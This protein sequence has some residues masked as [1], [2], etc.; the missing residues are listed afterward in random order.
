MTWRDVQDAVVQSADAA[1][2]NTNAWSGVNGAGHAVSH[3]FGFGLLRADRLVA[4]AQKWKHP[5]PPVAKIAYGPNVVPSSAQTIAG[6]SELVEKLEIAGCQ[7]VTGRH[8]IA[9]LRQVQL[10]LE[11]TGNKR[12]ALE[13]LLR[14]PSG[15]TSRLLQERP[16]DRS[17]ADLGHW[18]FMS[19][20]HWD[21]PATGTWVLTL[22][23]ADSTASF[24][25]TS[26]TLV[27][28]GLLAEDVL[29]QG[30][31]VTSA[32]TRTREGHVCNTCPPLAYMDGA[33]TCR[34]CSGNCTE[35]CFGPGPEGCAS[36]DG[37]GFRIVNR[38]RAKGYVTTGK[39]SSVAR[40][41]RLV[42]C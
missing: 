21:E 8:C 37:T 3:A 31:M 16:G 39:S 38:D 6:N 25:C 28:S 13:I 30:E 42:L 7:D 11:I 34:A 26:W 12:G 1:G 27:L 10:K 32:S 23:N 17:Y 14:S 20:L 18:T 36:L 5:Q 4:Y 24:T 33:G 15:F 2:L 41:G 19:V 22:K 9:K 40:V 35:G 29:A